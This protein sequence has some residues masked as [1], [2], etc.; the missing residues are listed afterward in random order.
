MSQMDSTRKHVI[1]KY[2][3]GARYY[4]LVMTLYSLIGFRQW[5]YRR[6][7]IQALRLRP[8]DTVVEIGC[9]TGLN[10][11]LIEEVIGPEGRIIGIDVTDAMLAQAKRRVEAHGWNNVS[12]V[13]AD[14]LAFPFPT[15]VN[16]ILST[17]ALL[18]MPECA[19]VIKSASTALSPGGS[20]VVLDLKR[21][22]H[23]P[24]WL[25]SA[26]LSLVRP[27]AVNE[28]VIVR[29]PWDAIRV[30]MQA[31]LVECSWTELF[32]GFAFLAVG[33]RGQGTSQAK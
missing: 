27:F 23:S 2:R 5:A 15:G 7:A 4:D 13:Q 30:A 16:A 20:F 8:G 19:Q 25:V 11:A 21:S 9:G 3:D 10:F 26:L 1:Q 22:E 29:R 14:A 31:S 24:G 6:K 28:E 32:F 18:F 17:F 12:F 33:T